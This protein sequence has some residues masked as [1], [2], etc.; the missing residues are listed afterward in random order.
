M[1]EEKKT[2]EVMFAKRKQENMPN[3]KRRQKKRKSNQS[4]LGDRFTK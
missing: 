2:C 3:R 4:L 1:I